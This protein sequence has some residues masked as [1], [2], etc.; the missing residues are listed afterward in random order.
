MRPDR[1]SS[2]VPQTLARRRPVVGGT[3]RTVPE[4]RLTHLAVSWFGAG[5]TVSTKTHAGWTVWSAPDACSGGPDEP[6]AGHHM[7]LVARD[8][9]EYEIT[10]T[11]EAAS[12]FVTEINTVDGPAMAT[13]AEPL[14]AM[15]LPDGTECPV[16]YVPRAAWGADEG[17]RFVGGEEVWPPAYAPTQALTVHHTAGANNDPDPAATI[18]AIYYY[19]AVTQAWGDIGYHLFIDEQGRVYEG[20]WSGPDLVP[21]FDTNV[22]AGVTPGL[23]TAGHIFSFNTGNLGVCLL[24]NLTNQGPTP[25]ARSALVNVLA[26]LARIGQIDPESLVNYVGPTGST[27]TVLGISGHRDWAATECPGNTFYPQLREL[28]SE[29][30]AVIA[31]SPPTTPP[32]SPTPSASPSTSPSPSPT[33]SAS[34]SPTPTSTKRH[35]PKRP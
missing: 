1:G 5:A 10:L 11:G 28:R 20:R 6:P 16:T 21:T 2:V 23:V 29:V 17:Y 24:G 9:T 27:R 26:S 33:A 7:L 14:S 13:A 25:A 19:Q 32:P 4:R 15:P 34:P 12:G 30:A 31:D 35:G 22:P 8:V 18:R 3:L